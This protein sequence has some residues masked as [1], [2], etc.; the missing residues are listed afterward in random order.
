MISIEFLRHYRMFGYAVFDLA[1]SFLGIYA[2]SPLLSKLL[3]AFNVAVPKKN[4]VFLTL[5]LGIVVHL[6]SGTI[7]PMTRNVFDAQGHFG[8]KICMIALC[9]LGLRNVKR[10]K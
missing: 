2:L 4:W 1:V 8:L 10:I 3:F 7:T 9:I 5:P 6:L